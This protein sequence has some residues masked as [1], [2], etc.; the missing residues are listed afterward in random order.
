M[1]VAVT[2]VTGRV[3]AVEG[4]VRR[5]WLA[6]GGKSELWEGRTLVLRSFGAI[7]Q[8]SVSKKKGMMIFDLVDFEFFFFRF[9]FGVSSYGG[10]VL[11]G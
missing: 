5:H 11:E 9:G 2:A 8:S 7:G 3:T 10:V 1:L 4:I 6:R